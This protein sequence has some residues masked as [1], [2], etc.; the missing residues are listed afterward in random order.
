MRE[1]MWA[2]ELVL[3]ERSSS[4]KKNELPIRL[5]GSSGRGVALHNRHLKVCTPCL[6]PVFAAVGPFQPDF[7]TS[8]ILSNCK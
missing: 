8:R 1:Q 4:E 5:F 6:F 7:R 3:I 2:S